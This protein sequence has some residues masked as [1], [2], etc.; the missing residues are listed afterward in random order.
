M[1]IQRQDGGAIADQNLGRQTIAIANA[2]HR[3][4]QEARQILL[5][6]KILEERK[7]GAGATSQHKAEN[8]NAAP[9]HSASAYLLSSFFFGGGSTVTLTAVS[10]RSASSV[11]STVIGV[12][13]S[14]SEGLIDFFPCRN[15]VLCERRIETV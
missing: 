2:A 14:I 15:L 11:A 7:I 12:S 9:T 6:R 10:F 3:L 5:L 4:K 13:R 8:Q 1:Q